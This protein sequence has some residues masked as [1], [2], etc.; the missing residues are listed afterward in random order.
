[1][2]DEYARRELRD[3]LDAPPR[4][5]GEFYGMTDEEALCVQLE[6]RDLWIAKV[7]ELAREVL[8]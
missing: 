2:S 3:L 7:V 1:M 8:K 4:D 6:E 5:D